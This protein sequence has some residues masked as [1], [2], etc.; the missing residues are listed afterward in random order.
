MGIH[1]AELCKGTIPVVTVTTLDRYLVLPS[2]LCRSENGAFPIFGSETTE[3]FVTAEVYVGKDELVAREILGIGS[4]R[5]CDRSDHPLIVGRVHHATTRIDTDGEVFERF[6]VAQHE[7]SVEVLCLGVVENEATPVDHF[8]VTPSGGVL[9][10]LVV[11]FVVIIFDTGLQ[12]ETVDDLP[13]G[14]DTTECAVNHF[15]AGHTVD[16]PPRVIEVDGIAIPYLFT[17][18]FVE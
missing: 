10:I 3:V 2:N 18:M 13:V 8:A 12:I 16:Q 14:S 5:F 9:P 7:V 11:A 6:V 17:I 15:F 4:A 1:I